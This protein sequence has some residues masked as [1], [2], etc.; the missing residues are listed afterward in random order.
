ML[1]LSSG[2][3]RDKFEF[4]FWQALLKSTNTFHFWLGLDN[5]NMHFVLLP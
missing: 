3:H 5:N 4:K 1:S 2:L